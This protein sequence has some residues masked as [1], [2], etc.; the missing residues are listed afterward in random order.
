MVR[1]PNNR[2]IQT[3]VTDAEGAEAIVAPVKPETRPGVVVV[4]ARKWVGENGKT[5]KPGDE[6][7]TTAERMKALG[8][9]VVKVT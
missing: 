9:V 6:F 5:Y 4:R 2:A 1:K 3:P 7:E 8:A